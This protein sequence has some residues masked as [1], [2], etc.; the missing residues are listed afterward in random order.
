MKLSDKL[1]ELNFDRFQSFGDA[2]QPSKQALLAFTG[3]TYKDMPLEDY[4]EDDFASAQDRVR[5]LSG[6]YGVLRPL[7]LI[8][9]YRLEMGTKLET[10]RGKN[11]YEYWG[12]RVT[13]EIN[14]DL[15]EHDGATILNCASNEYFKVVNEKKL[16]AKVITPVFKDYSKG[17]YKVISFYAKRARGMMADFVVRNRIQDVDGLRDF[18]AGGYAYDEDASTPEAPVFLRKQD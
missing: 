8:H 6:L 14:A 1:A 4:S 2:Q 5:I 18:T 7:D 9:P 16:D 17:K 12:D 3:D 10:E 11:L 15:A 13:E